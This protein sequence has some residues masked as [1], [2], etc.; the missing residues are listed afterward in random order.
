MDIEPE[1]EIKRAD[2]LWYEDGSLIIQAEHTIFRVSRGIL[3]TQS[4]VFRDMLSL[5]TPKDAE[6]MDGCPFVHLPDTA[7]DVTVFLKALLYYD[8]FEPHPAPT[9]FDII[10]GVLRMSH[11]YEVEALRK[12]ALMHI[13]SAYP[14]TLREWER[15][16]DEGLPEW[17]AELQWSYFPLI[18]LSRQLSLD[19]I[20]PTAFYEVCRVASVEEI[21]QCT[22]LESKDKV[23]CLEASSQ[24]EATVTTKILDFLW[25]PFLIN[26][27]TSQRACTDA[28]F[29]KR[30]EAELW[31]Q[32]AISEAVEFQ[33]LDIWN[34]EDWY[35]LQETVCDVCL[36]TMKQTHKRA[37]QKFWDE[38]PEMFGLPDWTAL[39][40]M[41]I[42]A[43][44]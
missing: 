9:T 41:K 23:R 11:K 16:H 8:F 25:S 2:G 10:A 15:L 19:W 4:P 13:S 42:A 26:G 12:R 29:S 21:I 38:L 40:V 22:G 30:R 1:A 35:R 36:S 20:L 34:K 44:K 31:R 37:R 18:F 5:P 24:L 32:R 14:T 17:S 39:E 3:A 43:Y 6:M 28:R 7:A 27:C 33:A